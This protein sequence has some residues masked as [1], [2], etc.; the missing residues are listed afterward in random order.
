MRPPSRACR[1]ILDVGLGVLMAASIGFFSTSKDKALAWVDNLSESELSELAGQLD[2]VVSRA[3][4]GD[5]LNTHLL[6]L[7]GFFAAALLVTIFMLFCTL[8]LLQQLGRIHRSG[9][10][11]TARKLKLEQEGAATASAPSS[12]PAPGAGHH[13]ANKE[14]HGATGHAHAV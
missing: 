2:L 9:I 1:C 3:S 7:I 12:Q 5:F 6:Q 14:A 8:Y 4:L 11:K 13:H 10:A